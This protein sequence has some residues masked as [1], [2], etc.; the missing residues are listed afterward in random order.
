ME[1]PAGMKLSNFSEQIGTK[2]NTKPDGVEGNDFIVGN[3]FRQV[4]LMKNLKDSAAGTDFSQSTGIMLKQLRLSSVT[5][6]FTSDNIIEGSTS[7]IQA[8]ID[9]VDSSNI[10]YH[11]SE[12][13]GFGNFDSGENITETNGNGAG[14]LN[15]T[16]A[17][18]I[19]PEIDMFSG[20]LL[21]IDNR[22][23]ITRASDQTEDIK[24]VIQ[25]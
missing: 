23:A 19:K 14:V 22:A 20:D 9:K 8:Y 6:G 11:Q 25:I 4:G 7:G 21:Y 12:V 13:T 16:Y 5:S 10:W 17:P 3:D 2:V 24:I 18:Y 1:I 15:A